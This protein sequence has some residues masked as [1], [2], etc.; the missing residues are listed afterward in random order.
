MKSIPNVAF[1]VLALSLVPLSNAFC[2]VPPPP[3]CDPVTPG[4]MIVLDNR[5]THYGEIY[6]LAGQ[7]QNDASAA[8]PAPT[9]KSKPTKGAV[10]RD[11]LIS[12][13]V[14]KNGTQFYITKNASGR[15]Y[16]VTKGG[17]PQPYYSH[18]QKQSHY[19]P[20]VVVD[21]KG[22]LYFTE[23]ILITDNKGH[24][25]WGRDGKIF[26]LSSGGSPGS[27]ELFCTIHAEDLG[28]QGKITGNP[29]DPNAVSTSERLKVWGGEFCFG[30]TET[31][32]IDTDT[33]YIC[34]V[35][36]VPSAIYCLKKQNGEWSKPD[37]VFY[38]QNGGIHG[39]IMAGPSECYFFGD[40]DGPKGEPQKVY[41]LINWKNPQPVLTP[42]KPNYNGGLGRKL[43]IVPN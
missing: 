32:A 38:N 34:S 39:L 20:D 18:A 35:Y 19:L 28:G 4:T 36:I 3:L 23:K 30:R 29:N 9:F 7:G 21:D 10:T 13:A 6:R 37:L 31:G 11:Q 1:A 24:R 40:I 8:L 26:K 25:T 12:Y 42:A 5:K 14:T 33:L 15:I 22:G 27:P 16:V 43:V 41:K 17:Q 2:Q